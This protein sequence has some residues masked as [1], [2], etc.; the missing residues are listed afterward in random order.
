MVMLFM[1]RQSTHMRQVPFFLGTKIAGT[2]QGLRLSS[3]VHFH[4]MVTLSSF[5]LILVPLMTSSV[6]HA[7]K[8]VSW[9]LSI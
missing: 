7:P 5:F 8:S 9:S 3:W 6:T 1:S 2:T 4:G